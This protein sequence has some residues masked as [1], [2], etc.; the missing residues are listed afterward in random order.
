MATMKRRVDR[1]LSSQTAVG[2]R[3]PRPAFG[4]SHGAV[5][6]MTGPIRNLPDDL[7]K[8]LGL[9]CR[10]LDGVTRQQCVGHLPFARRATAN[11]GFSVLPTG[12]NDPERSLRLPQS[13]RSGTQGFHEFR[14]SEAAV[15]DLTHPAMNC[16]SSIRHGCRSS[17]YCTLKP[18]GQPTR[19][20]RP[21]L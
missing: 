17:G 1:P 9:S 7:R 20:R 13:C 6:Q 21:R 14:C 12:T 18:A 2:G 5:I 15:R 3:R 10:W 19:A 16:R 11:G 8:N 4:L